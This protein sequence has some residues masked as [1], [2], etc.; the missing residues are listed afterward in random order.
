MRKRINILLLLM[1]QVLMFVNTWYAINL[2]FGLGFDAADNLW[3]FSRYY[4][5]SYQ[6]ENKYMMLTVLIL[7]VFHIL[8]NNLNQK[9]GR[10]LII[11]GG[12]LLKLILVLSLISAMSSIHVL[13]YTN[14]LNAYLPISFFNIPVSMVLS[15]LVLIILIREIIEIFK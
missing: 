2:Y 8:K 4:F 15:I 10:V 1:V 14:D 5:N 11:M 6:H 9:K 12:Y 7:L 13:N 3:P